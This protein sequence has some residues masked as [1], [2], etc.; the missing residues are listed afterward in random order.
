MC[1]YYNVRYYSTFYLYFVIF[2]LS[3][4]CIHTVQ[5]EIPVLTRRIV[6]YLNRPATT[7][8]NRLRWADP[9]TVGQMGVFR[10]RLWDE[11][12]GG[13]PAGIAVRDGVGCPEKN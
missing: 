2:I 5:Y 13:S 9:L 8:E 10:P 7:F 1:F 4:Q 12:P 3:G 6:L 11:A